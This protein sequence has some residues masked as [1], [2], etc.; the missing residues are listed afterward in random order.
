MISIIDY[1]MGNIGSVRN[2]VE[3]LGYDVIIPKTRDDFE[4]SS[5][6]ILPGVGSFSDGMKNLH[7]LG[8]VEILNDQVILKKKPFLG[9]CLGMQILADLGEEGGLTKGLGWISGKVTRLNLGSGYK[10]P[11][12][13]WNDLIL[14]H[15][16]KLF[17]GISRP[18]Y[19]FVHSYHFEPKNYDVVSAE[20]EYDKKI[21]AAIERDNIYGLQ[22]HTEKSQ[23]EG[24]NTLD[25]FLSIE[26]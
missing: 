13:G 15:N 14:H 23:Q 1:G 7:E 25:N 11:H 18:T 20:T 10:V 21:V 4:K 16:S 5:H 19:Y 3:F 26:V 22:F 12:M 6:I 9:L 2:A 8:F 24:I 17:S